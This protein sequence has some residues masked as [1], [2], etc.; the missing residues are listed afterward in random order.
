MALFVRM[1][2]CK[3]DGGRKGDRI[4]DRMDKWKGYEKNTG[5]IRGDADTNC[6][7]IS[8]WICN[9]CNSVYCN[10]DQPITNS[11]ALVRE[12]ANYTNRATAVYRRS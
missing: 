4:D 3:G 7:E 12:R 6:G 1:F 8:C 10:Y 9:V 11:V 5:I 2:S